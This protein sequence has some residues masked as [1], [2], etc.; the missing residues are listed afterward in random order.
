MLLPGEPVPTD[1]VAQASA[2]APSIV[3]VATAPLA[4]AD[5]QDPTPTRKPVVPQDSPLATMS[6]AELEAHAAWL[7]HLLRQRLLF[8]PAAA[9][10]ADP[11]A[12]GES[13]TS[14]TARVLRR[15]LAEFAWSNALGVRGGGAYFSFATKSHSYDDHPD[16]SLQEQ[17]FSSGF[18]GGCVG[19]VM[20]LGDVPLA[21]LGA[22]P[23]ATLRAEQHAAWNHMWQASGEPGVEPAWRERA[24][25][26]GLASHEQARKGR[27]YLL[28]RTGQDEHDLLVAF[29]SL[30]SDEHGH[31]IAYRVLHTFVP[32][33]HVPTGMPAAPAGEP[34]SA[35]VG[36]PANALL[37]ALAELRAVAEPRLL[38]VSADV[39]AQW[40]NE[41]RG[42]DS[43]ACRILQ[44]GRYAAIVQSREG[45][46]YFDFV[47]R[48]HAYADGV[49]VGLEMGRLQTGFAGGDMGF[50]LDLGAVPL[51]TA[52]TGGE[53]D[54][55]RERATFLRN[56]V[57][58]RDGSGKF[59]LTAADAERARALELRD[60][61]ANAGHTYL[62]RVVHDDHTLL[63]AMHVVQVDR[64]GAT[65]VW[66]ILA[67][68]GR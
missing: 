17:Q 37:A 14:G 61:A 28:R 8:E 58:V 36:L 27:T 7:Q 45:G 32:N 10:L 63:V 41:L 3:P 62:L 50:V 53:A 59:A 9:A 57:P 25:K 48:T 23:P 54:A 15:E 43:G 64:D 39:A 44:R 18:Y 38:A 65:L 34:P 47:K 49:H 16:L 51:A 60:A 11:A 30:A 1:S 22:Q 13:A 56:V 46:A 21:S 5:A 2:P 4:I 40:A 42:D 26:L 55:L 6:I 12:V 20:A 68:N 31:T 29:R 52:G 19:L 35:L 66:R 33:E 67:R 24:D